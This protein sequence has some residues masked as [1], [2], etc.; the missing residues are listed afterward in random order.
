M[1]NTIFYIVMIRT[2]AISVMKSCIGYYALCRQANSFKHIHTKK[3]F[4]F[5]FLFD[6]YI[7]TLIYIYK[8]D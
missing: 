5:P 7:G 2:L 6:T 3:V 8:D 4:P 1:A